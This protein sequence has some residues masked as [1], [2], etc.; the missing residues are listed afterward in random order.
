METR[1]MGIAS[2]GKPSSQQI[3]LLGL[4]CQLGQRPILHNVT[5]SV[6]TDEHLLKWKKGW[7]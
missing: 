7:P 6:Y 2:Q 1:A 4:R 3:S 5:V